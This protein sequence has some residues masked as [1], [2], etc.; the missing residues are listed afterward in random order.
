[1]ARTV[2]IDCFPESADR[3]RDD[4]ALVTIDVIRATTTAITAVA[5]GRRC[6]PV[7]SIEAAL[8]TAARLDQ[9][10]LVG[11][12][13]GNMPYGFDM[14]NSPAQL[15]ARTDVWRTM[16]LLSSSGTQLMDS[17]ARSN[18]AYVACLRNVT[19][20][21][22]HLADRH[23]RVAVL[24]AGTRGEFRDEDQAC[25]A[26]IAEGLM[27]RGYRPHDAGTVEVVQ[28]WSGR[29]QAWTESRSVEYLRRTNQLRDLDFI[30]EHL[31]DLDSV[32]MMSRGEV[33]PVLP[34]PVTQEWREAVAAA[35]DDAPVA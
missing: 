9:P 22:R 12:L 11:E 17:A 30:L 31:D 20:T 23:D 7:P 19:A 26:A 5:Q 28:R 18:F 8:P 6:Y 29:P 16:I 21:I 10:L 15:A 13:G 1:L 3:Y 34:T 27:Q 24:G 2:A 32:Y 35:D 33:V 4:W 25:C 14:T